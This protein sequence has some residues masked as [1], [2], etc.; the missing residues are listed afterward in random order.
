MVKVLILS[1]IRRSASFHDSLDIWPRRSVRGLPTA[2]ASHFFWRK[3][4][5]LCFY[6]HKSLKTPKYMPELPELAGW[7]PARG[8]VHSIR[9]FSEWGW[10]TLLLVSLVR[11]I[12]QSSSNTATDQG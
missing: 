7:E 11:V 9:A 6:S 12:A 8:R 5:R 3:N 10:T 4:R 2:A 1:R